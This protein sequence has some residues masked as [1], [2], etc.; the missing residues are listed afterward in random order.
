MTNLRPDHLERHGTFEAYGRAKRHILKMLR[1]DGLA[2]LGPSACLEDWRPEQGHRL[3]FGSP[4]SDLYIQHNA[5]MQQALGKLADVAQLRLPGDF[6]RAN[7]LAALG[8]AAHL[9]LS[10]IERQAALP[11]ARGLAHRL[12]RLAAG[13]GLV[14]HDNG[15]STTPDS[16]LAALESLPYGQH[17][18]LGGRSKGLPWAELARAIR[19]RAAHVELFGDARA[20]IAQALAAQDVSCRQ[21]ES[22][23][24]AVAGALDT[25]QGTGHLLF[26]PACSSFDAFPNFKARALVFQAALAAS[27]SQQ[28]V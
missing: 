14:V 24:A 28:K 27:L 4:E 22:L 23:Q 2:L 6:Q 8:L 17:L 9:G 10:A 26:S 12:E 1:A 21:H 15:V 13:E 19:Q 25:L 20:E 3:R 7:A 11:H 16:T 5:F 18:L